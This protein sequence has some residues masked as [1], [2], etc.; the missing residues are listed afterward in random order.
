MSADRKK[1]ENTPKKIQFCY[2]FHFFLCYNI[3]VVRIH[4]QAACIQ[5]S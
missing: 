3:Y 1:K 5:T 4:E 2:I